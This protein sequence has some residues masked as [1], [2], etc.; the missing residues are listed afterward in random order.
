MAARVT[1]VHA[2]ARQWDEA[3]LDAAFAQP[4]P[5]IDS[6]VEVS[7]RAIADGADLIIPAEGV[8]N[9]VLFMHGIS[10]VDGATVMDCV[11]AALL[12]AEMQVNAQRRLKLGVGRHWALRPPAEILARLH[13]ARRAGLDAFPGDADG[14]PADAA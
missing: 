8:L 9:E 6:F 12:Q 10:T 11:G 1:G 7:R 5:L 2:F 14:D 13:T 4:E 3:Q